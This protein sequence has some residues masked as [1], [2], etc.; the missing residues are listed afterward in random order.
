MHGRGTSIRAWKS[1]PP[2][3]ERS[4]Y[5]RSWKRS[6]ST[7]T[8]KWTS[9]WLYPLKVSPLR[10]ILLPAHLNHPQGSDTTVSEN[11]GTRAWSNWMQ[12]DRQSASPD[13]C[14]HLISFHRS[15]PCLMIDRPRH[16]D[17]A[18]GYGSAAREP[19]HDGRPYHLSD[20]AGH[21]RNRPKPRQES[22]SFGAEERDL[23]PVSAAPRVFWRASQPPVSPQF[24]YI[25]PTEAMWV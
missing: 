11:S 1:R 14:A 6:S 12:P 18:F 4:F 22:W 15:Y 13:G 16:V 17:P 5:I 10:T 19:D 20:S 25:L 24:G 23:P 7:G 8:T 21:S 3:S 9:R 2:S